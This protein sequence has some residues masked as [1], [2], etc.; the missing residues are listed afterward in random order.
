MR[1]FTPA[2]I[3]SID[4]DARGSGEQ[5]CTFEDDPNRIHG[6]AWLN[7][8]AGSL[9]VPDRVAIERVARQLFEGHKPKAHAESSHRASISHSPRDVASADVGESAQPTHDFR[10]W[11]ISDEVA[12][13]V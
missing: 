9:S 3:H 8:S 11:H 4:Q 2:A 1:R 12:Y 13:S 5:R 6:T 7:S 10:K